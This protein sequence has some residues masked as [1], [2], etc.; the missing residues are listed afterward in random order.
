MPAAIPHR[1]LERGS[2][3]TA[4][5]RYSV[6]LELRHEGMLSALAQVFR[7]LERGGVAALTMK[8]PVLAE[9]IYAN[10]GSRQSCDLDLMVSLRDLP[11]AG[12]ALRELGYSPA[13]PLWPGWPA[14]P[15]EF[16][17]VF[18][19]RGAPCVEL[20]YRF[21]DMPGKRHEAAAFLDRRRAYRTSLGGQAYIMEPEDEFIFL[22]AHAAR[23]F[24]ERSMWLDD[25]ELFIS[26]HRNL[27]WHVIGERA[28]QL[29]LQTALWAASQELRA[30]RSGPA[31]LAALGLRPN[32]VMR[33]AWPKIL[34]VLPHPAQ[35]R[36]LSWKIRHAAYQIALRDSPWAAVRHAFFFG[37]LLLQAGI[38]VLVQR[39]A[40][41]KERRA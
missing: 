33:R 35:P 4:E 15:L 19:K 13:K 27:K 16:H 11:A 26:N 21:S 28:R 34:P 22:C 14:N 31:A 38:D 37:L 18:E 9:R 29:R 39:A 36:P 25:L 8:G 1:Q 40:W 6:A 7:V 24:F 2:T 30:K 10:E 32:A 5:R 17:S 3:M 41:M 12:A 20:H 23:H